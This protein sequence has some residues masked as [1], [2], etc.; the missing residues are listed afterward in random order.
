MCSKYNQMQ[1][2]KKHEL[3]APL[4]DKVVFDKV[5]GEKKTYTIIRLHLNQN[6]LKKFENSFI[7]LQEYF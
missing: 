5:K 1:K 7:F 6:H 2:G 4:F 3:A